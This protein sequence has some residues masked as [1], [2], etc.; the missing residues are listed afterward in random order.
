MARRYWTERSSR[1]AVTLPRRRQFVRDVLLTQG[2]DLLGRRWVQGGG[3]VPLGLGDTHLHGDGGQLDH[4]R[5]VGADDM[6]ADHLVRLAADD[7][8]HERP[9][10]AA[11]EGDLHRPEARLIDVHLTEALARIGL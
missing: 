3:R 2:D 4:L 9:F 5:R 7:E 1:E 11:L 10:L 8:L 6:D